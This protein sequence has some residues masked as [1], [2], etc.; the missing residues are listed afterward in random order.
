MG[1]TLGDQL[2]K[3]GLVDEKQVKKSKHD[4]RTDKKARG[5]DGIEA[6]RSRRA[7]EADQRR[8][9][10]RQTDRDRSRERNESAADRETQNRIQQMVA[11]GRVD[12]RTGGRRRFYFESRDGRVP[13]MEVNDDTHNGLEAG[14]I[15]IAED[16]EGKITLITRESAARVAELDPSWLR[17]WNG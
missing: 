5:R 16:L 1:G 12:G 3:L 4:Q 6:D 8:T 7:K 17:A 11:S 2:L 13:L 15:G 10:A 9:T 14:R